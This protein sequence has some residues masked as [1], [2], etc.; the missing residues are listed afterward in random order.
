VSQRSFDVEA[1]AEVFRQEHCRA[2]AT[3]V[4]LLGD[5]E[6][7][8]GGGP[9]RLRGS[10]AEAAGLRSAAQPRRLDHADR[11]PSGHRSVAPRSYPCRPA[12]PSRPAAPVRRRAGEGT[13]AGR[14]AA[15]DLHLLS[16]G[17]VHRGADR[18][19]AA[20]ARRAADVR[21]IARTFLVPDST[22]AQRLVRARRKIRDAGVP[23]RV[24]AETELPNR[25]RAVIAV[26]YLVF[27]AGYSAADMP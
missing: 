24:P 15:A 19:D 1:I 6:S 11:S 26:V 10:G 23:Y 8:G 27:N 17:A 21:E 22:M 13:R 16:S 9:R 4:R 7:R 12:R 20:A 18:P 25:L 14:P 5:I 3:L 2:V